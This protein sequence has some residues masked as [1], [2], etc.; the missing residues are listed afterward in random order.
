MSPAAGLAA[1]FAAAFLQSCSYVASS[2]YLRESGRAAWTLLPHRKSMVNCKR[3][4][5]G[6]S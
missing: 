6:N 4:D 2:R 1:G 3:S 5:A